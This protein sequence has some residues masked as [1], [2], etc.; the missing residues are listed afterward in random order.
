MFCSRVSST[1]A[2]SDFVWSNLDKKTRKL[3]CEVWQSLGICLAFW[4]FYFP[5]EVGLFNHTLRGFC[6]CE[7]EDMG[8]ARWRIWGRKATGV[9]ADQR[10]VVHSLSLRW[11]SCVHSSGVYC[12]SDCPLLRV[13]AWVLL[14][15]AQLTKVD[16]IYNVMEYF[17]NILVFLESWVLSTCYPRKITY[18]FFSRRGPQHVL[19]V[20][21]GR[22]YPELRNVKF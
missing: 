13:Y 9:G 18:K 4:G 10:F 16:F 2:S 5:L 21:G 20:E 8:P 19:S 12:W 22:A 11:I 6:S 17:P 7:M 3:S 1:L 14:L 15:T